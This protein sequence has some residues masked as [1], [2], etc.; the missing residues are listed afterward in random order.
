MTVRRRPAKNT[1]K[2]AIQAAGGNLTLAANL[3]GCSRP[4][5]YKWVDQLDLTRLAGVRREARVD[6]VDATQARTS[7]QAAVKLEGQPLSIFPTVSAEAAVLDQFK[8]QRGVSMTGAQWRWVRTYAAQTDRDASDVVAEA[9]DLL[10]R[11][12]ETPEKAK[13][14]A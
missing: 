14:K 3:L 13:A 12:V 7:G 1:V 4:T 5:L 11:R 9:I 8:R 2:E 6:G 10:K